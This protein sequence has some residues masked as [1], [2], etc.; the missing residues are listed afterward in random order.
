MARLTSETT[1]DTIIKAFKTHKVDEL[2]QKHKEI[3]E[4]W[5]FTDNLLRQYED[6]ETILET[7]Q[8]KFSI[9]RSQAWRD[10]ADA[11]HL[12]GTV[13]INHK[14][15]Y[16]IFYAELLEQMAKEAHAAGNLKVAKDCIKEAAEIR[17]LKDDSDSELYQ[18]LEPHTFVMEV[19]IVVGDKKTKREID[20][21]NLPVE[22]VEFEEIIE[23]IERGSSL[24]ESEMKQLIES[25]R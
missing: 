16:R 9:S 18:Y 22:D 8:E 21:D 17:G 14:D 20:L 2:S 6:R 5:N 19:N 23:D 12:F 1:L 11:K 25:R 10:L 4:R 24:N 13:N 7:L 3:L 15:Y